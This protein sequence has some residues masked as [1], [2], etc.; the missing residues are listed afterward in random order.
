MVDPIPL[1]EPISK[2]RDPV[3][4]HS[5]RLDAMLE[6]FSARSR[7]TSRRFAAYAMLGAVVVVT[8]GIWGFAFET[9]TLQ[10]PVR[11]PTMASNGPVMV[12]IG[13]APSRN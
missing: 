13:P 12:M 6:A 4:V 2:H 1:R 3:S 9:S 8:L 10:V 7:R 5:E 11:T